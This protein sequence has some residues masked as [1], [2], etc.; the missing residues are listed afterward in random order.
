MG[1]GAS[2]DNVAS[3]DEAKQREL[4]DELFTKLDKI[5][6]GKL[7]LMEISKGFAAL[8]A[9]GTVI[10]LPAK[11]FAKVADKDGDKMIDRDEFYNVMKKV[12]AKGDI[13]STPVAAEAPAPAA[14]AV[15]EAPAP[16]E[17]AVEPPPKHADEPEPIPPELLLG[18]KADDT[19]RIAAL[20]KALD[21][22]GN[23]TL[24]VSELTVY[25]ENSGALEIVAE[26]DSGKTGEVSEA[27]WT[28][29]FGALDATMVPVYLMSL[30][31]VVASKSLVDVAPPPVKSKIGADDEDGA[32]EPHSE[33]THPP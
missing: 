10:K 6:D 31:E 4:C 22:N 25:F 24:S 5:A 21:L 13:A 28:A 26:M 32:H 20:F 30:E 16:A 18:A 2:V 17:T 11:K 14:P 23:G 33:G 8:E 27:E 29:F 15:A 1:A 7:N 12:L 9:E 19:S 3:L